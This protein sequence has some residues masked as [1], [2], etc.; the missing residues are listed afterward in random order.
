MC[1]LVILD[2]S[3]KCRDLSPTNDFYKTFFTTKKDE[4]LLKYKKKKTKNF[5][6]LYRQELINNKELD[7][8]N[9][10]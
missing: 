8:I 4:I 10:R 6:I 7:R 1:R 3:A 9:D 2:R 5:I